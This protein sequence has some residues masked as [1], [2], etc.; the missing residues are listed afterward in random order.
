M[1]KES[2]FATCV[3]CGANLYLQRFNDTNK[4]ILKGAKI[5]FLCEWKPKKKKKVT[6]LIPF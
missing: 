1:E 4:I 2:I 3:Q 5:D 6:I